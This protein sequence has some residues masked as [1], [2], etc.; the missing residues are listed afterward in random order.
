MARKVSIEAV[1]DG[2]VDLIDLLKMNALMDYQSAMDKQAYKQ[3]Q[4]EAKHK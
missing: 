3:A 1:K 4:D 2:K